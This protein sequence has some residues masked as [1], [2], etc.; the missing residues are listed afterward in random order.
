MLSDYLCYPGTILR[1]VVSDNATFIV[2]IHWVKLIS[3]FHG[4]YRFDITQQPLANIENIVKP[5]FR[6]TN[7]GHGIL[8]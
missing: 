1:I 3:C 6:D 4:S 8:Y 2:A 5:R 7:H